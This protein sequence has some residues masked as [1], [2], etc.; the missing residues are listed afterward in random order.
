[1]LSAETAVAGIPSAVRTMARIAAEADEFA[2]TKRTPRARDR[3]AMSSPTHA[4][5]HTAYQASREIRAKALVIFTRILGAAGLEVA[6]AGVFHLRAHAAR[7]DLPAAL[8][9]VGRH[10][11]NV[12]RWRTA[13]GMI[14]AGSGS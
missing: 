6:P 13:E 8:P 12:P 5:A 3:T 4:L 11:V 1:M 10:G 2:A 9:R 7:F 14:E